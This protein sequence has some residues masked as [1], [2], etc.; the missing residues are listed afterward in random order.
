MFANECLGRL[1]YESTTTAIVIAGAFLAFILQYTSFR[2]S[3]ARSRTVAASKPG[4]GHT[5]SMNGD[6]SDKS[7][8]S[9]THVQVT[10]H[11]PTL[12]DP[13]SVLILEMGIIFHSA[14]MSNRTQF[15][16]KTVFAYHPV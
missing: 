15:S 9:Q 13:L 11:L 8:Q 6:S 16:A 1:K 4:D 12:D 5:E 10:E 2:L 3:E 14:S 7:S